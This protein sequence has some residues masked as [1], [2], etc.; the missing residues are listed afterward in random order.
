MN[1][2]ITK[3]LRACLHMCT[4]SLAAGCHVPPAVN[5][6]AGPN[7]AWS[8]KDQIAA[9]SSD[10]LEHPRPAWVGGLAAR[11]HDIRA[12]LV[13]KLPPSGVVYVASSLPSGV[14]GVT[15]IDGLGDTEHCAARSG[16]VFF[17]EPGSKRVSDLPG[18][19]VFTPGPSRPI[20]P[21]LSLV[22][23]VLDGERTVGFLYWTASGTQHVRV[24]SKTTRKA[25]YVPQ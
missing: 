9:D 7:L 21:E 16:E 8:H 1:R 25:S 4:L 2:E 11:V 18:A 5:P 6:A 19:A 3:R 22:E 17:R 10:A 15:S 13:G 20:V 12:C 24:N 23:A 14:T